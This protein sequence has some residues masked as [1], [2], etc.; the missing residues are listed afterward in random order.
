MFNQSTEQYVQ[1][2]HASG[3]WGGLRGQLV[4]HVQQGSTFSTEITAEAVSRRFLFTLAFTVSA[5]SRD[6]AHRIRGTQQQ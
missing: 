2:E 6:P 3:A 4:K 1:T 5:V